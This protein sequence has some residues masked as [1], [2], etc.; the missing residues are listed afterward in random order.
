M[1][2]P[3]PGSIPRGASSYV[4]KSIQ[5]IPSELGVSW[6]ML[7]GRSQRNRSLIMNGSLKRFNVWKVG[8]GG[9][10]SLRTTD[11]PA[12]GCGQPWLLL[13]AG[14]FEASVR[15]GVDS[16]GEDVGQ[17][18]RIHLREDVTKWREAVAGASDPVLVRITK[19][20]S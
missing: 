7:K 5:L 12:P 13:C 19:T 16:V 4:V 11:H 1:P 10:V 20:S 3:S 18:E 9:E 2:L 6:K 15:M 17:D 14:R 8:C